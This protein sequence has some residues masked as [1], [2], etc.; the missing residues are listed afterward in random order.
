ME[1]FNK[2][3]W[4]TFVLRSDLMD[5]QGDLKDGNNSKQISALAASMRTN[6]FTFPIMVW[7]KHDNLVL[8]WHQRIKALKELALLDFYLADDMI[9]VTYIKADNIEEAIK[10]TYMACSRYSVITES[11]HKSFQEKGSQPIDLEYILWLDVKKIDTSDLKKIDTDDLREIKDKKLLLKVW[12]IIK[13]GVSEIKC[14]DREDIAAI[15]H[16]IQQYYFF[17]SKKREIFCTNREIDIT[18]ILDK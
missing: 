1:I 15:E 10:I 18:E 8:D 4:D 5:F 12:D 9:P 11:W 13:I 6:G 3:V 2:V 7:Y 16:L 14:N 17:T